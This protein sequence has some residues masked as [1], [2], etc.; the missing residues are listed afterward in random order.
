MGVKRVFLSWN[1]VNELLDSIH[2]KCKDDIGLVAGVPRGGQLLAILYSHRFDVPYTEYISNHYTHMLVLDD[3]ADSGKTFSEL[4]KE[5]PNPK[6]GALHYKE[7]STF[8][9]DFFSKKIPD[10][11]GWIVYPW[12]KVDSKSIQDYLDN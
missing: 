12:E 8:K 3:I 2:E 5:F 11:Y 4:K 6:Y 9:P 7:T 1:D 10:D